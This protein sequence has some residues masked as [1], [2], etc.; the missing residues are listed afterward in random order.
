MN[1]LTF[2]TLEQFLMNCSLKKDSTLE[3]THTEFGK[4]IKRKF[5]I[6][7]EKY[8][9]YMKLYYKDVIKPNKTHNLIERQLIFKNGSSGPLL[10]DVDL[11]FLSQYTTRQYSLDHVHELV[12]TVLDLLSSTFEMDDDISFIVA[13]LEKP[14]PRT[15]TK[16][17]S[18]VIVKDGIHLMF[19]ISMD[20]IYH[21]YFRQKIIDTVQNL[22]LWKA[23]PISN[24]FEDVFD[25][26]ISNGTNG[27]LAPRSMKPDDK[28]PYDVTLAYNVN[29]D[30]EKNMWSKIILVEKAE[31]VEA[32]YKQYYKQLF[33][34]NQNLPTLSLPKESVLEEIRR[35]EDLHKKPTASSPTAAAAAA[36]AGKNGICGGD[37]MYQISIS[38]VRQIGN[39]EDLEILKNIFLD[40]LEPTKYEIREAFE[41]AM[42]LPETYYGAGSYNKWIK[43]GFALRNT[44]IY[45]LIAWVVFSAQSASFDFSKDIISICDH[46]MRWIQEP[47]FG[48]TRLSLMYWSK[49]DAPEKYQKVHENTIDFYL[50]QTIGGLSLEQLTKKGKGTGCSDYD[51]AT[52][53]YHLKKGLFIACGIKSNSWYVFNGSYWSKDDS[54][55]TLRNILSTQVRGLYIA[56][57]TKLWEKAHQIKTP[58]GEVDTENEEHQILKAR[59]NL[60]IGIATRLGNTHEKDNFMRECK[61]QFYD[62]D[63][64]K[65]LDQNR[66]LLC[67]SNGVIDFKE[68]RFRKGYPEDYISKC[69]QIDY[70]PV[71]REREKDREIIFEIQDYFS[72]LFPIPEL[73]AYMWNH[74]ASV[75]IGDTAKTQCLHYYTGV[76]QNGKSMLVKL[77]QMILGDYATELDVSFFVNDRPS[78]GKAT[79]ELLCLLGTRFAVTAEPSEGEKLNEGPMK[80]LTSGTDRIKYRGLFKDEDSFLPQVHS[81]IMAN[82]YLPV[83][84]RDHGTWRRIRVIKFLSLFVD[85]PKEDSVVGKEYQFKKE[86][87]FD[88]KFKKWAPVFISL[89]IEIAYVNQGSLKICKIVEEYSNEYKK[90]QDYL[91]EFIGDK[92]EKC[93]GNRLKKSHVLETFNEW[94]LANYQVKISGKKQELFNTMDKEFGASISN[95][96]LDVKM[97]MDYDKAPSDTCTTHETNSEADTMTSELSL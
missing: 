19:S 14:A 6:P 58:D 13:V 57:S 3:L 27:W 49:H 29:F 60:F 88:D 65:K 68:K 44:S 59:A 52:V 96:W 21:Q 56:K 10:I 55:T 66:Y 42:T 64:E 61:E 36:A 89:L 40:N 12:Q 51:I 26:S 53:V 81:V 32:F 39:R 67:F 63:F 76:G 15:V 5:H 8:D 24:G 20:M 78:R 92:I 46:W 84:S 80:A 9:Q 73:C 50:D 38:T 62:K 23:L 2:D 18:T 41:F 90:G 97:K 72:K 7:N 31:Q 77:I 33:V 1:D 82:H 43:V 54:G 17:N 83:K 25:S 16:P 48:V 91:A 85:E 37:E 74:L 28:N 69:T 45:L 30:T 95:C 75:I 71:F 70:V 87:D 4:M 79:P 94:Y 22:D 11:Q 35:Y 86:E 34:R 47:E 93:P